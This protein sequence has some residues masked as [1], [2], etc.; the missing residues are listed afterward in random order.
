MQNKWKYFI[1]LTLGIY[2]IFLPFFWIFSNYIVEV[3][4]VP[5]VSVSPWKRIYFNKT[6]TQNPI[7]LVT[8]STQNNWENYPIPRVRN[9]TTTYF[10][11]SSCVDKWE[12][13]CDASSSSETFDFFVWDRDIIDSTPWI[14]AGIK[15][16]TTAWGN[17]LTSFGTTFSNIP[18]VFTTP[19]SSNQW[20]NIWSTAW[21][22]DIN[23]SQANLI[24][25][26][27]QAGS[28]WNVNTC[29]SW[30]PN[31]NMGYVAIDWST[32]SLTNFQY[33]F[34]DI[35]NSNWTS[36]SFSP[37]Y[38]S[39]PRI[40][41]TQNDDDG[42]QD[43]EYAWA[44]SI[45]TNGAQIRYCEA[46]AINVCNSHTSEKLMW[47][48][49]PNSPTQSLGLSS[50]SSISINYTPQNISYF[51]EAQFSE[52]FSVQDDLGYNPGWYTTISISSLVWPQTISSNNISL[53]ATTVNMIS[54]TPNT[55]VTLPW[56]LSTYQNITNPIT[57]LQRNNGDNGLKIWTYWTK[58]WLKINFPAY[59]VVWT[60]TATITYTLYENNKIVDL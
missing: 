43:P 22:D 14:S 30:Q 1:M 29:T 45:S 37:T 60:Y 6:Y 33:W 28:A 58:P 7:V 25:C 36:I 17:T 56:T 32:F 47:Y 41:A 21:V 2:L 44:K 12:V 23:T 35:S 20:S 10:E 39:I 42:N 40:M 13:T 55:N 24:W 46:D 49:L 50:P 27:H 57:F 18:Y 3:G 59:P 19:Q 51:A 8:P 38:S 26:V 4:Q 15:T 16:V 48:S 54:G 9:V 31:E 34:K 5:S 11:L 52:Y 53:K